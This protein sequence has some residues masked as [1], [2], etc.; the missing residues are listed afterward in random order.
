MLQF[1]MGSEPASP[2]AK[3]QIQGKL[4]D[5]WDV[6]YCDGLRKQ[7]VGLSHASFAV[8]FRDKDPCNDEKPVPPEERQSVARAE[9]HAVI[10]PLDKKEPGVKLH[11]VTDN[12]LVI[13]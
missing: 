3:N 7:T 13:L 2:D 4:N 9:L 10:L 6:V 12:E 11:V 8:W 1:R 5:G